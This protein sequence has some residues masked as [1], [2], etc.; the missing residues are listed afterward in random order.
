MSLSAAMISIES[1]RSDLLSGG[2]DRDIGVS[3]ELAYA[4]DADDGADTRNWDLIPS[5]V[6]S[7]NLSDLLSLGEGGWE[8]VKR[9][10]L[11]F[12]ALKNIA[13]PSQGNASLDILGKVSDDVS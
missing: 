7:R 3:A 4:R 13:S 5:L 10:R 6:G 2:F 8:R 11:L 12:E 9:W 1:L